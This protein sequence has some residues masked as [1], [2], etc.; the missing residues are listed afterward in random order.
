MDQIVQA[1]VLGLLQG[2]TEF[3]PISSSGHLIVV[4]ALLGWDD[5]FLE[6]LAFSVMLHVGDARGAARLLRARLDPT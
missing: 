4:P 2:L 3:L 5:P 1:I 6:S